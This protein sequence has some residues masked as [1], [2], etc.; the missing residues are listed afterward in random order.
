MTFDSAQEV[1]KVGSSTQLT[2]TATMPSALSALISF[3]WNRDEHLIDKGVLDFK[4]ILI[5]WIAELE[6]S[7][8][9]DSAV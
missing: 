2:C 3:K 4:F 1:E 6:S 5:K 7:I 9:L 8:A